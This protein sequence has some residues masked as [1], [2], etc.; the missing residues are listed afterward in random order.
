MAAEEDFQKQTSRQR[1]EHKTTLAI[2]MQR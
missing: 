1:A 2:E